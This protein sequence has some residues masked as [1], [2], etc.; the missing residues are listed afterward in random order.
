MTALDRA[1]NCRADSGD[2]ADPLGEHGHLLLFQ[3]HRYDAGIMNRLQV[4]GPVS[5]LPNGPG[6]ESVG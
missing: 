1:A 5:G 3:H 6:H 2:S 4:K